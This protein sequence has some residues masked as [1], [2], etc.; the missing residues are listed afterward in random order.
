MSALDATGEERLPR[1]TP[2][3][4]NE[5]RTVKA[6]AQ[7]RTVALRNAR[8]VFAEIGEN[9]APTGESLRA[10]NGGVDGT[11]TRDPRRDRPIF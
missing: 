9:V 11:R 3:P 7:R 10:M 4:Q 6:Y 2:R 8:S 1:V 5:S